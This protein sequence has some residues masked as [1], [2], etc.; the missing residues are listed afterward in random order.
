MSWFQNIADKVQ[1]SLPTKLPEMNATAMLETLT[2][3]TP[4]LAQERRRMDAVE[5][6]KERVRSMLAGLLPWETRDRERDILVDECRDCILNLSQTKRTF[7]GPYPLP[8]RT[9]KTTDDDDDKDTEEE[10]EEPRPCQESLE[11]LAK[12]E[13]LPSLLGDFDFQ[14]HVGLIEKILAVD[15][16]LVEMQSSLS[17]W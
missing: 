5:K 12:L 13:P 4:E 8:P 15:E 7:F 17:G 9:A 2:L 6:R 11:M 1:S 14:A 3:T 16:N 10:E